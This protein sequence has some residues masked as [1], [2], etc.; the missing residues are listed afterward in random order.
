MGQYSPLRKYVIVAEDE[1]SIREMISASLKDA[2]F[3]VLEAGDAQEVLTIL[4]TSAP[5]IGMLFTDVNMPGAM[6]GLELA[7]HV[8][9]TWPWITLLIA[10]GKAELEPT[11][12]P[13]GSRFMVK[14]YKLPEMMS[15][16]RQLSAGL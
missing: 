12:M 15:N 7:H 6:D 11:D 9:R 1:P 16:V 10:S 13:S 4:E 3:A 8:R 2:D 14:P 5:N